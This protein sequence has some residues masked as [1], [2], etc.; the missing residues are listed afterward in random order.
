MR[1]A[2]LLCTL[3]MCLITACKK[4][5]IGI[6]NSINTAKRN[7]KLDLSKW[8]PI[9]MTNHL[10]NSLTPDINRKVDWPNAFVRKNDGQNEFY[11]PLHS[12]NQNL[13]LLRV[14]ANV[15]DSIESAE[16]ILIMNY[17][18]D[19]SASTKGI[20]KKEKQGFNYFSGLAQVFDL[21]KKIK[22]YELYVNGRLVS[23]NKFV[24]KAK[25]S[26]IQIKTSAQQASGTVCWDTFWVS[27]YPDGT[28]TWNYMYTTCGDDCTTTTIIDIN[29]SLFIKSNC[30]G[31]GGSPYPQGDEVLWTQEMFE[32]QTD[33][34]TRM[35]QAELDIYDN[36]LTS[37]QRLKYLINAKTALEKAASL[38]PT[39]VW[40]GK[41]DAFRHAHFVAANAESLGPILAA[42]LAA[43]HELNPNNHPL[44]KEMDTRN[45]AIGIQL[46][47]TMHTNGLTGHFFREGL[48]ILLTQMVNNGGLWIISPLAS[49]G[50][51][52]DGVSQLVHSNE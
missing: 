3:T 26:E 33:Y 20:I 25:N 24:K 42:R 35:S 2:L 39:S 9:L 38:F 7:D 11:L 27:F 30:G 12:N 13:Q 47:N 41:G 34:R 22:H 19:V 43:A 4:E 48:Q 6:D 45:N 49:N 5:K 18:N 36:E 23:K 8:Q 44:E 10:I 1:T 50:A 28:Q 14:F 46:F 16:V 17:K 21:D 29:E 31:G 32:F 15:R 40:N 51:P 37:D 52:I